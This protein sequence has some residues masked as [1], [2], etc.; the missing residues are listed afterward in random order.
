MTVANG[1]PDPGLFRQCAAA[2][3][4]AQVECQGL[5]FDSEEAHRKHFIARLQEKPPCAAAPPYDPDEPYQLPHDPLAGM[6]EAPMSVD[7]L[8]LWRQVALGEDTDLDLKE[9]RFHGNEVKGP[10]RDHLADELAAFAN[11]RGGRLVLGV[12]DDRKPQSLEPAQLDALVDLVT[13]LCSDSIK[14]P[15]E[16]SVFRVRAPEPAQGGVL[17]V[18]IPDERDGTQVP[19]RLFSPA[20]RQEAPDGPCRGPPA[21]AGPRTVGRGGHRHPGRAQHR[22]RQLAPGVVGAVRELAG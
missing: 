4:S 2:E 20:R 12:S 11:G 21:V 3:E 18:E 13:E 9:A 1:D 5:T 7:T 14:P 19:W 15:L 16:L 10:R 17:V 22:N 8:H 6:A